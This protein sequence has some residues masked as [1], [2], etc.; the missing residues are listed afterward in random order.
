MTPTQLLFRLQQD[1][2]LSF[3]LIFYELLSTEQN[4]RM[5]I[6]YSDSEILLIQRSVGRA[7]D[8]HT[9]MDANYSRTSKNKSDKFT[10]TNHRRETEELDQS[11]A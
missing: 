9:H 4:P 11:Y 1:L 2:E 6:A 7:R 3:C 8:T 5:K 10:S